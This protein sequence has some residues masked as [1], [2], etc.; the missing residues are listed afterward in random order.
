MVDNVG[1]AQGGL[2]RREEGGGIP[3]P[4]FLL[5]KD[6]V[7]GCRHPKFKSNRA[8]HLFLRRTPS[9]IAVFYAPKNTRS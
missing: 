2:G 8:D 4:S 6:G 5:T 3:I 7:W 9:G 1:K